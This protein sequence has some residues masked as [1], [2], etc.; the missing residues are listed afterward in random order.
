MSS[1][2]LMNLKYVP[3]I[4]LD[5]VDYRGN[6]CFVWKIM[7]VA[8]LSIPPY[9]DGKKTSHRLER[10]MNF[11]KL[12]KHYIETIEKVIQYVF[13]GFSVGPDR[14]TDNRERSHFLGE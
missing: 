12:A 6:S 10:M 1:V 8:S 9:Q 13:Q 5:G 14:E 4:N 3:I 7:N 11:P 2:D